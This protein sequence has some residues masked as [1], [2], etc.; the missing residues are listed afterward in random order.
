MS[1]TCWTLLFAGTVA[2]GC[3]AASGL[4]SAAQQIPKRNRFMK[5]LPCVGPTGRRRRAN[6]LPARRD[7][8]EVG[9][10][11]RTLE[12]PLDTH[13]QGM[14]RAAGALGAAAIAVFVHIALGEGPVPLELHVRVEVP[15]QTHRVVVHVAALDVVVAE[16]DV[17]PAGA[18]FPGT[19]AAMKIAILATH[20]EEV[21]VGNEAV[22]AAQAL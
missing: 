7:Q 12:F 4:I 20:E 19:L 21:L 13:A 2:A 17:I 8:V 5:L 15:V 6:C 1:P 18:D 22:D 9:V 3:C 10:R 11:N 16:I 14:Q